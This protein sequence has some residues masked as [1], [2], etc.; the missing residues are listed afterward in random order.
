MAAGRQLGAGGSPAE[1]QAIE[2]RRARPLAKWI[3]DE[4]KPIAEL[5][6]LMVSVLEAIVKANA[7]EAHFCSLNPG[8]ILVRDDQSVQ[9]ATH[10]PVEAGKTFDLDSA[11]YTYPE[12]FGE[13]APGTPAGANVYVAGFIFY[14]LLLGHKLFN[15]QFKDVER[16]GNLGWFTW[17]ADV[18]KRAVSLKEMNRYPA[19]VCTIVDRMIEKNPTNRLTDVNGIARLFGNVSNA[20]MVYK[21]ARDPSPAAASGAIVAA[22]SNEPRPWLANLGQ[23]KLWR[24][25]WK[26]VAP[27]EPQLRQ[28]S[29]EELESMFRDAETKVGKLVSMF[30]F[31]RSAKRKARG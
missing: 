17:H 30:S 24:M 11:K 23:Q 1:N 31:S 12:L 20:T 25:L 13:T 9:I 27:N 29:I 16:N 3:A 18:T 6:P 15:A 26:R 5:L 4:P 14:E 10:K 8:K 2:R 7:T 21:V 19:F 28:R 22:P